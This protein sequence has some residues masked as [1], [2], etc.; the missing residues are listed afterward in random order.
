MKHTHKKNPP[1]PTQIKTIPPKTPP[2]K[3][4]HTAPPKKNQR[5]HQTPSPNFQLKLATI[6][7]TSFFKSIGNTFIEW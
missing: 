3:H 2:P 5:T 6:Y 4:K 7:S 1:Q